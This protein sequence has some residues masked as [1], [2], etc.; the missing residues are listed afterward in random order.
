MGKTTSLPDGWG[1]R[2][3]AWH[4]EKFTEFCAL[5]QQVGE[6]SPHL[7]IVG[8]MARNE[9]LDSKLW[10]LGSYAATYSLPTAQVIWTQWRAAAALE[11]EARFREWIAGNWRGIITRQERR[12]VRT[13][14]K[15][16]DCLLSFADWMES[17]FPFLDLMRDEAERDPHGYYDRVWESVGT[18]KYFGRYINI[19]LVEGLR[20]F[21]G[22]PAHLY[23]IRSLGGW[24]PKKCLAYLYPDQA[25]TLLVDDATGN[26]LTN[27]L[28]A[29]LLT[30][31]REVVPSV[32][33]YV[34]A[35]MLCEYKGAYENRTQY[36][37]WTIDQEPPLYRKVVEHWSEDDLDTD[38]LW[39][40]RRALFPPEV[41]GE[42]NGWDG[43]RWDLACVL[44]DSGYIWSDLRYDYA[45]TDDLGNPA[46]REAPGVPA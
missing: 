38:L 8:Y 30:R 37:G 15:M 29:D 26:R 28:A 36:V 32:D 4:M 34:L 33:E 20:R 24:S 2:P 3:A 42:L 1:D 41:L 27:E 39:Q 19:R 11:D 10:L 46:V 40:A 45:A 43:T 5:K 17:E 9:P 13:P 16:A 44:R 12:C 22:I 31:V 18:I 7:T 25:E 21:C 14:Q 35:A 23:D 6:P